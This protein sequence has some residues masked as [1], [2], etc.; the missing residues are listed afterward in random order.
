MLSSGMCTYVYTIE[1]K[2]PDTYDFYYEHQNFRPFT[3][4]WHYSETVGSPYN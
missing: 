1:V 2:N 3:Y 4:S